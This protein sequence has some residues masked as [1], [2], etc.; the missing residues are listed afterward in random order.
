MF[1]NVESNSDKTRVLMRN[2]SN[3]YSTESPKEVH[4]VSYG[5]T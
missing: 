5:N 2:V 1:D 3:I 4:A